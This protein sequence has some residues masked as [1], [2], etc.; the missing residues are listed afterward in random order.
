MSK[1]IT[2]GNTQTDDASKK[3]TV[4][5]RGKSQKEG[6]KALHETSQSLVPALKAAT[7][8]LRR[9]HNVAHERSLKGSG[10][11]GLVTVHFFTMV[12]KEFR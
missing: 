6:L 11:W 7:I 3:N 10:N 9:N 1:A 12:L 4:G 2:Y 8:T 5:F